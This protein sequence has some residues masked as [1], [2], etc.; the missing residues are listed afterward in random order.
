MIT[1]PD[2]YCMLSRGHFLSKTGQCKVWD[3]EADG[4]CR[5]DGIGSVVI[6]RLED[7]KADNDRIIATIVAGATNHSA[8]AIS[9]THPH[10]GAQE[11]NYMQVL[12]QAG[13][14]PFDV[15]YV[16]LHGTGTQAGDAIESESVAAVFAPT[17][18]RRRA[19]QRLHL[20]AL[21]SNIGHGEAAA[22]IASLIK[23]LLVFQKSQI[24]PHAGI[25]SE[26]NPTVLK[27]LNKRNMGLTFENTDWPRAE[28]KK[29]MAVVN[30]FGAH[31]GNT[32]L[33]L[34]DAPQDRIVSASQRS[35]HVIAISAKSK[36]SLR[37]N[38]ERL[39]MY[40]DTNPGCD[41][42]D[43]SYT[44]CARRMH[45]SNRIATSVTDMETLKR[46]LLSCHGDMSD[47]RPIP[48]ATPDVIF[49]YT[50]QG[51]FYEGI[52]KQL[53]RD[54]PYF[55]E[56]V[57][58]LDR[59]VQNFGFPS[60]I[61]GIEGKLDDKPSALV[62]QLTTTVV[63]ISLTK[64][65]AL[66]G[67]KPSAVIGHS[68]GEYAA[69]EAAGVLS[70]AD[71]LWLVGTRARLTVASCELQSHVMISVRAS[72]AQLQETSLNQDSYEVS[73]V[74]GPKDTV[75]SGPRGVIES[76]KTT[77]TA[78]S[79]KCTELDLPFAFHS[80]QMEPVLDEF[81]SAAKNVAF[82]PP[83]VP[84]ISPLLSSCVFDGKTLNAKYLRRASRETVN[85]AGA[86]EAARD[87]GTADDTS[88]WLEVGP[89]PLCSSFI[90]SNISHPRMIPSLRKNEDAFTT[91]A[92][93]LSMLYLN[94]FAIC[95]NEYFRPVEQGHKVLHLPRYHFTEKNYWIQ[96][97]GTW[98][99][100]KA[101]PNDSRIKGQIGRVVSS[102][103]TSS[104]QSII[105]EDFH[106]ST[107]HL[108]AVSDLKDPEMLAAVHGHRMNGHGVATSVSPSAFSRILY[109]KL[110]CSSLSG[111]TA[112]TRW[113]STCTRS[114][115]LLPTSC[116]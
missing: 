57:T 51:A 15:S 89:H 70:A 42:G 116:T 53:F 36:S 30:S 75:I 94:G 69:M 65:W 39:L 112:P 18:A 6:K 91:L 109:S 35:S 68:L 79:I 24:P 76:I 101:F 73:C 41:L 28:D 37:G 72:V 80:A 58:R 40:L 63:E 56:Q 85:F 84:F 108:V 97:T 27:H 96:Y 66:L 114:S 59:I 74:N 11:D 50:G 14:N 3:K 26:I 86:L 22:G 10:A 105:S 98:T 61:P 100:D 92:A 20:G 2:N 48:M 111:L 44:T 99:L 77:L 32:T 43:L 19:D 34:E 64:L 17:N 55:R 38:I 107:G 60:V 8:E 5:A 23:V 47:I 87:F 54:F 90:E 7:A 110:T 103:R 12:D 102:L 62:T 113:P 81:E 52:S 67:I 83:E 9:I 13:V 21:K 78:S 88:V 16:E 4:Y 46:F 1:N 106:K 104:V 31:G 82:K 49:A 71:A 45:H 93:S 115:T 33:L 95:W 25:K 29:R